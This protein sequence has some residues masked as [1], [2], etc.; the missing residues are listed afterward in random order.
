MGEEEGGET[1]DER[2]GGQ[3][4]LLKNGKSVG[5]RERALV[6]DVAQIEGCCPQ[7]SWECPHVSL[8]PHNAGLALGLLGF[9]WRLCSVSS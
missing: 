2:A 6:D 4:E 8:D 1:C 7:L 3:R 5:G 9:R